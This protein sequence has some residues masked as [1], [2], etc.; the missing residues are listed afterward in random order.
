[1]MA[2]KTFPAFPAHAQPAILIMWYEA[3]DPKV[4]PEPIVNLIPG[5]II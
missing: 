2:E 3:H 4:L 1:M 5:N